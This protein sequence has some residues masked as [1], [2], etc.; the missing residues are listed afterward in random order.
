MPHICDAAA[1]RLVLPPPAHA[2]R[3]LRHRT[4]RRGAAS[5]GMLSARTCQAVPQQRPG[6]GLWLMPHMH[7][8]PCT[9]QCSCMHMPRIFACSVAECVTHL[10]PIRL[11]PSC[12][13]TC[14]MVG[15][16]PDR[17]KWRDEMCASL[18]SVCCLAMGRRGWRYLARAVHVAA[19]CHDRRW[20]AV[21]CSA[22]TPRDVDACS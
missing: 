15:K 2:A 7:H 12:A 21:V 14:Y 6:P 9:T 18:P 5:P 22:L 4:W 8:A 3:R 11:L 20:R 13:T 19:Q 10:I 16:Q 1:W 17:I